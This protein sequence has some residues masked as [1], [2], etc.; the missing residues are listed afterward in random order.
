MRIGVS[1][2]V[3]IVL[4]VVATA[5][6][7]RYQPMPGANIDHVFISVWDRWRQKECVSFRSNVSRMPG[8][9]CTPSEIQDALAA[10]AK[11]QEAEL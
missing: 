3:I 11:V 10:L 1:I 6:Q 2:P 8:A 5:W 7:F 9:F 4:T